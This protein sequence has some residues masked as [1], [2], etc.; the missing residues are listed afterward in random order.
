MD[1]LELGFLLPLVPLFLAPLFLIG[2]VWLDRRRRV[3]RPRRGTR[4]R[5]PPTA[6]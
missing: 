4:D 3:G 1:I 6:R 2:A 5:P